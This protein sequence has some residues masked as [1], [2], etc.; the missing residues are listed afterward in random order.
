MI[1][2]GMTW[3]LLLSLIL[4]VS[5]AAEGNTRAETLNAVWTDAL[6]NAAQNKILPNG[7][8]LEYGEEFGE[9]SDNRFALCDVDADG[10]EELLIS[11]ETAPMAGMMCGVYGYDELNDKVTCQLLEFPALTF[12]EN[13]LVKAELSHDSGLSGSFHSFTVY[14]YLSSAD[15]YVALATVEAWEKSV[16]ATDPAGNPFPDDVDVDGTGVVY[17]ITI[18]GDTE[19]V[20]AVV[21]EAWM[22]AMIDGSA[23]I[24]PDWLPLTEENIG[25][26]GAK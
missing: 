19:I 3:A 23:E 24:T 17:L 6:N 18:D 11:W 7:E 16:A 21:Y 20:D 25:A 4:S 8:T 2:K 12:Y 15:S 9:I 5:A 22:S 1:K 14:D 10:R 13:G 26:L